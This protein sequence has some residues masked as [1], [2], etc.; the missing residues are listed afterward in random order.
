MVFLVRLWDCG[1]CLAAAGDGHIKF[2]SWQDLVDVIGVQVNVRRQLVVVIWR[3]CN[4]YVQIDDIEIRFR[5]TLRIST[6]VII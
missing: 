2:L 3:C 5:C 6:F 4:G 1:I